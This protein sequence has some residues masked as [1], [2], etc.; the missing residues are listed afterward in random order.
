M[1]KFV[2]DSDALIKL[3][4]SGVLEDFCTHYYSVITSE[5]KYECVDEGKKRLHEDAFKIEDF[6]NKKILKIVDIKKP[7][8]IKENLGK[9][10]IST[11]NLYFQ[12]KTSI[13]VTDDSTFIKYLENSNIRFV[14]PAD[15]ILLMKISRKID[16]KTALNYL[17]NIKGLIREDV[18]DDIKKDIT[19][20]SK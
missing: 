5:V 4:K 15:I 10:E 2:I 19:E 12:E 7:R 18:Y 13:I 11:A 14:I 3:T 9:W 6:I 1:F 17:E 16:K 20:D 8:K